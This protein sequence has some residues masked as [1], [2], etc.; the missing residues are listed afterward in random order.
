MTE[1]EIQ[2]RWEENLLAVQ[3]AKSAYLTALRQLA[4]VYDAG[5]RAA[6]GRNSRYPVLSGSERA[7]LDRAREA[8]EA[9]QRAVEDAK[10]RFKAGVPESVSG[11]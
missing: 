7:D 9:A 3:S 6:R 1:D 2:V 10:V 4:S 11:Q 5:G 8:V